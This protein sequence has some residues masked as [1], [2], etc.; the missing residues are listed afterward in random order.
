MA[1]ST[2]IFVGETKHWIHDIVEKAKKLKVGSGLGKDN[3]LQ[4]L[5][6]QLLLMLILVN[7]YYEW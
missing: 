1:L 5:Y 7:N 3:L 6:S 2:V 4:L